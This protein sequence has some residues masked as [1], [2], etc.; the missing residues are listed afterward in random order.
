MPQPLPDAV[1]AA[2]KTDA[3]AAL[4]AI[5]IISNAHSELLAWAQRSLS[6]LNAGG[7]PGAESCGHKKES[8][9]AEHSP[10]V[11]SVPSGTPKSSAKR[12][13]A[14]SKVKPGGNEHGDY[15]ARRRAQR[16][17]DDD[18]LI[19]A[20]EQAPGASIGALARDLGKSR[21]AIQAAL[22]RLRDRGLADS[23]GEQ[24]RLTP[25]SGARGLSAPP[26][27]KWTEPLSANHVARH[28]AAGRVPD[29][30]VPGHFV[31]GMAASP[32]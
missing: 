10:M 9:A 4:A 29:K 3:C 26:P 22:H 15:N 13:A 6:P 20:M 14:K 19:E 28:T 27:A 1:V 12:K 18:R 31:P 24:W 8:S 5:M 2:L 11:S 30:L 21:G 16:D 23:D 17:A 32:Q 25:G 7:T